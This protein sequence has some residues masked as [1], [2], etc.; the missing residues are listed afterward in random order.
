MNFIRAIQFR[1]SRGIQKNFD[2]L[3]LWVLL[4]AIQPQIS[5]EHFLARG[6]LVPWLMFCLGCAVV[7]RG[8]RYG[9]GPHS[10]LTKRVSTFGALCLKA[11][12][13]SALISLVLWF[14]FGVRL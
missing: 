12:M 11:S 13:L 8:K 5:V 9:D 7:L 3:L 2:L 14:D 10:S 6:D 1:I 4:I